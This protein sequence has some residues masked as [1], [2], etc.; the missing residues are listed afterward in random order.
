MKKL[1]RSLASRG[2][3]SPPITILTPIPTHDHVNAT[4]DATTNL[5]DLPSEILLLIFSCCVTPIPIIQKPFWLQEITPRVLFSPNTI[6]AEPSEQQVRM[7]KC[8]SLVCRR[9]WSVFVPFVWSWFFCANPMSLMDLVDAC[10]SER[11]LGRWVQHL[12]LKLP[13]LD[14]PFPSNMVSSQLAAIW[15]NLTSLHSL[16]LTLSPN[17]PCPQWLAEQLRGISA[18]R[19]L[20]LH[21]RGSTLGPHLRALPQLEAL[22]IEVHPPNSYAQALV[23]QAQE[24]T[25]NK[26]HHDWT[27]L[28]NDI[29]EMVDACVKVGNVKQLG[30]FVNWAMVRSFY[31]HVESS[32]SLSSLLASIQIFNPKSRVALGPLVKQLIP[33]NL[34]S[35][36]RLS[37]TLESR[38]GTRAFLRAMSGLPITDLALTSYDWSLLSGPIFRDFCAT[39]EKLSRLRLNLTSVLTGVGEPVANGFVDQDAFVQGLVSLKNLEAYKGPV[40]LRRRNVAGSLRSDA[41]ES[42]DEVML[43]LKSSGTL[44]PDLL[45]Q[46]HLCLDGVLGPQ[47]FCV[48]PDEPVRLGD[49][50]TGSQHIVALV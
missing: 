34:S 38:I 2:Q 16:T 19:F 11:E 26:V 27:E 32:P 30:L 31:Q 36:S 40:M 21:I 3:S 15:P 18:L 43:A 35:L 47:Q 49:W 17:Y 9:T 25:S 37:L 24:G 13:F 5:P 44:G 39:F 12:D 23:L 48:V 14:V 20:H 8:L 22:F 50:E 42:L 41:Q 1:I 33:S 10:E 28:F 29:I 4:L 46:W 45:L 6:L 7:A